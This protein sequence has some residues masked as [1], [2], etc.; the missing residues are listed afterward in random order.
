MDF[1]TAKS[2]WS[3]ERAAFVFFSKEN[4]FR[5]FCLE[6]Q[7]GVTEERR[8]GRK[9]EERMG[10]RGTCHSGKL[11]NLMSVRRHTCVPTHKQL[12]TQG[13]PIPTEIC[14]CQQTHTQTRMVTH[15]HTNTLVCTC[16]DTAQSC[17]C[18]LM[19]LGELCNFSQPWCAQ[20]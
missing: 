15:V 1:P 12:N 2:I 13:D 18:Q 3:L 6:T 14:T 10:H 8:E 5:W 7:E 16:M 9:R 19:T 17:H 4:Q 20:L 11:G